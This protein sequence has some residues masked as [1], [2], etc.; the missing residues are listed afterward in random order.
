MATCILPLAICGARKSDGTVAAGGV[1]FLTRPGTANTRVTGYRDKDKSAAHTLVDGGY[2][3][4][5]A[6]KIAVFVDEPCSVRIED[7]N[8]A[9][10]DSFTYEPT[11]NAGLVEVINGGYTGIDPDTG[12][13]AAGQRTY[14]N[15]I[16]S[17]LASS[18]GGI[19]GLYSPGAGA[20]GLPIGAVLSSI[21]ISVESFG[22]VGNGVADDTTPIQNTIN[23][24]SALG[25]GDVFVPAG[26][27][28]LTALLT[29]A[30]TGVNIVGAGAKS[31][32]RQTST[33]LGVLSFTTTGLIAINHVVR[34]IKISHATTSTGTAISGTCLFVSNV[35]VDG[36][37]YRVG[38]DMNGSGLIWF[39]IN[40][41]IRGNNADA[42]SFPVKISGTGFA[43]IDGCII[44]RPG[45]SGACVSVA[46]SGNI[47]SG[48]FLDGT[49]AST[50]DGVKLTAGSAYLIGNSAI[51]GGVS[52][53][54]VNCAAGAAFY[55]DRLSGI[56]P[57]ILDS[58]TATTAPVGYSFAV[59][60]NF[61]PLPMNTEAIRAVGTAGGITITV[62]AV[63]ACGFGR[64][65]SLICSNTSGGAVTWTFNAQYVLSAA[66]NPATGN[67]VN[68][69]LEY[70]PI[71][72]KVY[73]I[74]RAATAN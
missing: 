20:T 58:R 3:L 39:L 32:L 64:K 16:L 41:T 44:E 37:F 13:Y 1:V 27:Y 24:V 19:D 6:G 10:V 4:D 46:T 5:S 53:H 71:D 40:S 31:V 49:L 26:T 28:Q 72:N 15:R 66:V 65:F 36:P 55:S 45:T 68:L 7:Q 73:E 48:S 61:T 30:T 57:D 63:A 21:C 29:I 67:R 35:I 11:V 18:L 52:G 9:Q 42:S 25:G 14:L 51:S 60:G 70:N 54:G 22:A 34:N 17:S 62:N 47:I 2:L 74:S 12:Q 23:F 50:A 59:N 8:G 56:S 43:M 33:T 38:I 69:L